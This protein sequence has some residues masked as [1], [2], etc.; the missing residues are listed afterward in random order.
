DRAALSEEG[1]LPL[2]LV[3]ITS[4]LHNALVEEGRQRH[5]SIVVE[6]GE[7]QEGH[8]AAVLIANGA[9]AIFPSLYFAVGLVDGSQKK[10]L[11]AMEET[12]RRVMSKMGICSVDGY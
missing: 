7:G 5:A 11:L 10:L 2:P 1:R 12:L 3:L 6:S 9:T 8:D 4:A